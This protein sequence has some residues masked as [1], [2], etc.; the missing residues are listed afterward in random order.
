MALRVDLNDGIRE[1]IN[2]LGLE[3]STT[4]LGITMFEELGRA[5]LNEFKDEKITIQEAVSLTC[6]LF[7]AVAEKGNSTANVINAFAAKQQQL[8]ERL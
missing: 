4:Q 3:Y 5:I 2:L 6:N 8:L 7:T 1:L